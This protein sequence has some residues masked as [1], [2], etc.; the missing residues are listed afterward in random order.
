MFSLV[1]MFFLYEKPFRKGPI[2]ILLFVLCLQIW[3][4]INWTKNTT[5]P[6]S[7]SDGEQCPS[8]AGWCQ[9][10][11]GHIWPRWHEAGRG[12]KV[13]SAAGGKERNTRVG[14]VGILAAQPAQLPVICFVVNSDSWRGVEGGGYDWPCCWTQVAVCPGTVC[15]AGSADFVRLCLDCQL[16]NRPVV[17]AGSGMWS[18]HILFSLLTFSLKGLKRLSFMRKLQQDSRLGPTEATVRKILTFCR[19][20][21]L[22][23][24]ITGRK[25]RCWLLMRPTV[26]RGKRGIKRLAWNICRSI[27]LCMCGCSESAYHYVCQ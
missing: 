24:T 26:Y 11:P 20:G 2:P 25:C 9:T 17:T 8:S 10:T 13:K 27:F 19:V 4:K 7:Q 23:L 12:R 16:I 21:E 6:E 1:L 5:L 22:Y 18:C 3:G 15:K 14:I